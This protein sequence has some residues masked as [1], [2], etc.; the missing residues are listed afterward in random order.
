VPPPSVYGG[1]IGICQEL[2][3]GGEPESLLK[4]SDESLSVL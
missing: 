4:A 2:H 1:N 3:L